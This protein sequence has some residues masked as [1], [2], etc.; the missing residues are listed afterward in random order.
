MDHIHMK[1]VVLISTILRWEIGGEVSAGF[2]QEES[3]TNPPRPQNRSP[4]NR[5]LLET[6]RNELHDEERT[7]VDLS[8]SS[9]MIPLE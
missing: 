6:S 9:F 1:N 7:S 4:Q 3:V 2:Q 5:N 8:S